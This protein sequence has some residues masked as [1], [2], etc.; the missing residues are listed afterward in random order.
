[1]IIY[2]FDLMYRSGGGGRDKQLDYKLLYKPIAISIHKPV[3]R[4]SYSIHHLRSWVAIINIIKG[5]LQLWHF[6]SSQRPNWGVISHIHN[7]LLSIHPTHR[8]MHMLIHRSGE[9]YMI[10]TPN[11]YQ[12]LSLWIELTLFH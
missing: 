6:H 5:L 8:N 1:M 3:M 4:I 9:S 11:N 12:Q 7:L 2:C 10:V